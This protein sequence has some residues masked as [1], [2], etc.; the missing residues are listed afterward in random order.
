MKQWVLASLSA[1]ALGLVLVHPAAHAASDDKGA[2]EGRVFHDEDGDG[3]RDA[4]EAGLEGVEVKLSGKLRRTAETDRSGK[5][6][7]DDLGDGA[8]DVTVSL[9]KGWTAVKDFTVYK[10]L[11]VEGATLNDVDFA[12]QSEDDAAAAE[13]EASDTGAVAGTTG[14]TS[15]DEA[16]SDETGDDSAGTDDETAGD[17]TAAS[18]DSTADDSTADDSS[19]AADDA[20]A[21]TDEDA[22]DE[23][24]DDS[25]DATEGDAAHDDA[26]G[27]DVVAMDRAAADLI[28]GLS[29]ADLD[30]AVIAALQ[31]A[32]DSAKASG[33]QSDVTKALEAALATLPKDVQEKAK[34]AATDAAGGHDSDEAKDG[35]PAEGA[36]AAAPHS[37]AKPAGGMPETG[38]G[39]LALGGLLAAGL[40]ALGG[41]GRWMERRRA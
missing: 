2:I 7:F 30:P 25:T 28:A 39:A 27:D 22:D 24:A 37:D 9:D 41:A 19:D 18:D 40:A 26:A 12:L 8:Y 32:L 3:I 23:T 20:A 11:E 38:G 35:K 6:S 16:S 5:F 13:D 15:G 21:T 14:S 31:R 34:A 4:G 29:G 33:D 1:F 10:D 17:D 36:M